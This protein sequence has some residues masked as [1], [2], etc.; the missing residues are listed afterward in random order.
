MDAHKDKAL[1]RKYSSA[2]MSN[3]KWLKF[4]TALIK[5]ET[6][7]SAIEI[8]FT[9]TANVL[10]RNSSSIGHIWEDWFDDTLYGPIEYKHIEFIFIPSIYSYSDFENGPPKKKIQNIGVLIEL[11]EKSGKFPIRHVEGGIFV[12]G[13]VE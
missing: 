1:R 13:Y 8:G 7:F 11:L 3:T 2:L 9:D 5:S 12:D 4:F 6:E 10:L